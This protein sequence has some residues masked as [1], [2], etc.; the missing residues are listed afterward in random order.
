MGYYGGKGALAGGSQLGLPGF[1]TAQQ[2]FT[3]FSQT[4]TGTSLA[5]YLPT[6]RDAAKT[7]GDEEQRNFLRNECSV[8]Q[9]GLSTTYTYLNNV[10][11][12][13]DFQNDQ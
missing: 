8:Y 4:A 7:S 11:H 2:A 9:L 1:A 6:A 5:K 3:P 13:K 12:L 10:Q